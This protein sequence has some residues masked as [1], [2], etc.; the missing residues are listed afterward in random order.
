MHVERGLARMLL[1]D[2]EEVGEKLAL[3]VGEVGSL[4]ERDLTVVRVDAVDGTPLRGRLGGPRRLR[5]IGLGAVVLALA[6]PA[7]LG[8]QAARAVA[9][10]R[11]RNPSS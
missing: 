5:A 3:E 10:L 7:G 11:N 9:L 8:L 4:D 1:D 6:R 2:R